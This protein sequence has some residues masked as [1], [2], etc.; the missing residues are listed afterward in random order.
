MKE[1]LDYRNQNLWDE[2]QK[3]FNVTFENSLTNEYGC[4]S[5]NKNIIFYIDKNNLCK[6]SFT[7]EM[8]HVYLR[9]KDCYISGGL[10]NTI[11]QNRILLSFFSSNLLDHF[12][13]CLDHIKMLP[14]YLDLGFER[15]KFILDY[16]EY[17]FNKSDLELLKL[18]YKINN[19]INP[20][21]VDFFIGKQIAILADPNDDFDYSKELKELKSIDSILYE[22]NE[23]MISHWKKIKVENRELYED[24]Y[25]S[26]LF[27]YYQNLEN[28]IKANNL[29]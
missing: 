3:N 17:K 14:I 29:N 27:E 24:D 5:Q 25:H 21:A 26:V 6:S 10:N 7:H 13:N 9:L 19:N 2:I 16:Y 15:E 12:G 18:N 28:W 23:Q 8:L 4:F 20:N 11:L 22:A 1:L